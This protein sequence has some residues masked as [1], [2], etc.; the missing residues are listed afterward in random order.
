MLA[1][2][3]EAVE[4]N[5]Q[6]CVPKSLLSILIALGCAPQVILSFIEDAKSHRAGLLPSDRRTRAMALR[7]SRIF[8]LPV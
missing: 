7:A 3:V 5:I 4:Q 8:A 1:D 2:I 6:K